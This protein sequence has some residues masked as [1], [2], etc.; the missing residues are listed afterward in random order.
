MKKIQLHHILHVLPALL[1][2]LLL[3]LGWVFA[4]HDPEAQNLALRLQPPN[5]GYPLGTD[6]L[7]RCVL[8]RFLYGGRTTLLVVLVSGALVL[9]LGGLSAC[10]TE[11]PKEKPPTFS[12]AYVPYSRPF[13]PCCTLF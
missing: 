4:P 12:T 9:L 10:F 13:L 11:Q 2:L 7:G 5:G 3:T 6:S 1:I 8:S